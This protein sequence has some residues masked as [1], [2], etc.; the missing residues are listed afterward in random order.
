MRAQDFADLY[1][2][3]EE[4]WWFVGMREVTAALLDPLCPPAARRRVLDAGCGTG[5]NL[6][7]LRRYAAGGEVFGVDVEQTA[8][9]FCRARG[10]RALARASVTSLPF[11]AG[12]FDLVTSFDVLVQLPGEGADEEAMREMWRVLRPGG[13]A[14]VRAAAYGW[15][16]SGHDAALH[17]QRR[18][19]LGELR[20]RLERAG[21]RTRRATYANALLLPV[22]AVRRLLLKRVGLAD[23]GSD[24]R[25]LPGGMGWLNRALAGVLGGEAR[26]LRRAGARLPAGLSAVCVV[27]KPRGPIKN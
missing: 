26:L 12:T 6:D 7:W 15:M 10:H 2:L 16:R 20:R 9:D 22:A 21:F 8:L 1:A 13:V 24:V 5:V 17:T 14:F 23:R 27:E 3:E 19:G 11:D 18:Y 4:F 25:P